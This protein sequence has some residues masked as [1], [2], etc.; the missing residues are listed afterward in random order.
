MD[1]GFPKRSCSNK[2]IERDDDSKKNHHALVSQK[3][4]NIHRRELPW[5]CG[6]LGVKQGQKIPSERRVALIEAERRAATL[7]DEIERRNLVRAGRTEREV[8]QEIYAI[9][10]Q[11]FGAEKHWHKRIVR[12]GTNTLT[13]AADNPPV[14]SIEADDIVYVDLGPVFEDW[15]ADLGR[16]YILGNH[17]GGPLVEA[18]PI[19]FEKVQ[20]HYH[21]SRGITGSELYAYAQKAAAEA[22]WL[23]WRCDRRPSCE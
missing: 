1:T 17:P 22:G 7:F 15:E 12:A 9:A 11:Q 3:A 2:K 18:L 16:T 8:E 21:A 10:L 6:V 5:D 13:L 4:K 14:R 23:F 20:A 19:V